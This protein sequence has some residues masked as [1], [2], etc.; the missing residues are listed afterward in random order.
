MKTD[1]KQDVVLE[2]ELIASTNRI[3][4]YI[5]KLYLTRLITG[6][7]ELLKEKIKTELTKLLLEQQAE[8]VRDLNTILDLRESIEAYWDFAK[9]HSTTPY[10][11][12]SVAQEK[13]QFEELMQKYNP[14][15]NKDI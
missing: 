10:Q 4:Y 6:G 2:K 3:Y 15:T 7:R 13:R 1:T 8:F 11:D 5:N 14:T 9:D 12:K